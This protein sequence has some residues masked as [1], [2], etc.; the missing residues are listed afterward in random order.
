MGWVYYGNY[1]TYFE[2][3]RSEFMRNPAGPFASLG[4]YGPWVRRTYRSMISDFY[5]PEKVIQRDA[6]S[7]VINSLLN[8]SFLR[9][10]PRLCP[11]YLVEHDLIALPVRVLKYSTKQPLVKLP[12]LLSDDVVTCL[13]QRFSTRVEPVVYEIGGTVQPTVDPFMYYQG[14][15]L[16]V[17]NK[18]VLVDL[19]FAGSEWKI[20]FAP[21]T[22]RKIP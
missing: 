12:V 3:A 17:T 20:W 14:I 11:V 6:K 5:Y 21:N 2:V 13:R 7:I 4:G 16:E 15:V 10:Q 1:L 8:Y 22:L 9:V 18:G 19:A